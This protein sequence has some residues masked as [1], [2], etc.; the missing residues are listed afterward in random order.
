MFSSHGGGSDCLYQLVFMKEIYLHFYF[1]IDWAPRKGKQKQMYQ[2]QVHKI[3]RKE[4]SIFPPICSV[5]ENIIFKARKVK[6]S[7]YR[8]CRNRLCCT[9]YKPLRCRKLQ[10]PSP[11]GTRGRMEGAMV[12]GC[13]AVGLC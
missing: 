10:C 1:L 6:T 3:L 13:T 4:G 2:R 12:H 8:L 9:V 5:A 11:M 7:L